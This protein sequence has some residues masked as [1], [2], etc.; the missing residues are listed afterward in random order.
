M[1]L[2]AYCDPNVA[3]PSIFPEGVTKPV[4]GKV[5]KPV[6]IPLPPTLVDKVPALPP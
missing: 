2:L 3:L 6:T 5:T 1:L 4:A